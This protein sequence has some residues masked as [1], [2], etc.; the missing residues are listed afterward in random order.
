MNAKKRVVRDADA[1]GLASAIARMTPEQISARS[2]QHASRVEVLRGH[3][4][5]SQQETELLKAELNEAIRERAE[6]ENRVR[7]T[8]FGDNSKLS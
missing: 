5:T 2:A 8:G 4:W 3:W 1:G 6:W 7:R